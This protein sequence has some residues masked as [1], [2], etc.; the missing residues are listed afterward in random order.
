M[1]NYLT[2]YEAI[3]NQ[4]EE[5]F[6]KLWQRLEKQE[7]D[8]RMILQNQNELREQMVEIQQDLK[9]ILENQQTLTSSS[10]SSH[11]PTETDPLSRATAGAT[12]TDQEPQADQKPTDHV[13]E[14]S[15]GP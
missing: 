14:A 1:G 7:K 12:E 6:E 10:D 8:M 2:G 3:Q 15:T 4:Q 13:S 5:Q 9:K 11:Q